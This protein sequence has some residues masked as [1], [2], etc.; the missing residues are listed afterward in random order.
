MS[1]K[2]AAAIFAAIGAT[3]AGKTE[4]I[5]QQLRR[6]KPRRLLVWDPK[7]QSDYAE[8]GDSVDWEGRRELT[9]GILAAGA[10]GAYRGILR[11]GL[12]R[13]T[14]ADRFSWLCNV[15][16]AWGN[17]TI[18]AE[19]LAHTTR[20]G[21]SPD[22]WLAVV[23]LGR[24]SGLVVYGASQ[25]PAL[26][27]KTFLSAATLIHCGRLGSKNDRS[28]MANALDCNQ[29]ELRDLAPLDWIERADTGETRRGK[30]VYGGGLR[31]SNKAVAAT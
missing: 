30:L 20:A 23:T 16:Y 3:G 5:R 9:A 25:S 14:Y 13:S 31:R 12:K 22:G 19:E 7:P 24:S 26:M 15:A 27:D 28:T 18:V 2:Q 6:E 21:W 17:C 10:R 29:D 11:P 8:F 4:W 1:T